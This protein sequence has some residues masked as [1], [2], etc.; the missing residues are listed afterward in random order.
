[1]SA[2]GKTARGI[3]KKLGINASTV[4]NVLKRLGLSRP[5][6]ATDERKQAFLLAFRETRN[7]V[8]SCKRCGI[9]SGTYILWLKKYPEFR[10]AFEKIRPPENGQIRLDQAE[11][12]RM[13]TA[14][15]S[16]SQIAK[17]LGASRVGVSRILKRIRI[18][19]RNQGINDM[20]Q[21]ALRTKCTSSRILSAIEARAI[22]GLEET[23]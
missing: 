15:A 8:A 7:A 10:A 5:A 11:I 12:A 16:V 4:C 21:R 23:R 17:S 3:G 22:F 19:D 6:K 2:A 20:V 14:G 1:M 13:A 18:L 9:S